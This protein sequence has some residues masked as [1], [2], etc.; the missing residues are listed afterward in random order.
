MTL[1]DIENLRVRYPDTHGYYEAV[2]GISFRLGSERLGLVGES[3]S[4]KSSVG[5][6]IMRLLPDGVKIEADRL[7]LEGEDILA[8]PEK[9]ML[10]L[11]GK[12]M[13]M[14]LQDPRFSLNPL[15]PVGRQIMEVYLEHVKRD[16]TQARARA[17]EMLAQ[18]RINDPER[19]FDLYP[20]EISGGMGQRVMIAMMLI[21][22]PRLV[23][24]DEPTSALDVTVRRSVLEILD[25]LVTET[26]AG[27]LLIS[28]DLAVVSQ[29]CDRVLILYKGRIVEEIDARDL[30]RARHPY[31][32]ALLAS[33]PDMR[34]PRSHL[35]MLDRD[36]I[37]CLD[38]TP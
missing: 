26:G 13:S 21:A 20:H 19:T 32:Q 2:R 25:K 8:A 33:I 28:H 12:T 7:D 29:F 34:H 17:L 6:A 10:F 5:R 15:V 4:G 11:R 31:T 30:A 38:S 36:A 22:G 27:L 14:I 1:L 3:G 9:R 16:V 24:A 18:V 23:I 35:P 37:A